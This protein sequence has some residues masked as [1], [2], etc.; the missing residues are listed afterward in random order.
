MEQPNMQ[1]HLIFAKARNGVIGKNNALPW[2]LPE[3][4]AH[5]KQVTMGCPVI[6]G[7]KTWGL[8]TGAFPTPA[9]ASQCGSDPPKFMERNWGKALVGITR[10]AIV[11]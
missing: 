5:F 6:M 4:M 11:L 3:D 8:D 2:H 7:R 9:R 10:S 1:L